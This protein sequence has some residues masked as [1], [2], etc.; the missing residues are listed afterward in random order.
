M[1]YNEIRKRGDY[2]KKEEWK[3]IHFIEKGIEYEY[4]KYYMISN[5]GRIKTFGFVFTSKHNHKRIRKYYC[6]YGLNYG[7]F[8]NHKIISLNNFSVIK[9]ISIH[10]LVALH[11][12]D[13]VVNKDVINHKDGDK[14]NNHYTN[15]EWCTNKENSHHAFRTGLMHREGKILT[16][17][18]N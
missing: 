1:I 8:K 5:Y 2:L 9:V 3:K 6:G 15:L 7:R 11:F 4:S 16:L 17:K 12:I 18:K 10:R 14:H 13:K